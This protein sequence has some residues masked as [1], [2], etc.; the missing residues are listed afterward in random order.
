[1]SIAEHCKLFLVYNYSPCNFIKY[2][3]A[4]AGMGS[5]NRQ[6]DNVIT[7]YKLIINYKLQATLINQLVAS[8]E[9]Y[10]VFYR[11]KQLARYFE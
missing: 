9:W 1:M 8:Y 3:R 10:D 5:P 4:H 11:D 7:I 6:R 2:G